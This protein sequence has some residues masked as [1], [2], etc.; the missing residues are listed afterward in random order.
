MVMLVVSGECLF[1]V[2]TDVLTTKLTMM[3]SFLAIFWISFWATNAFFRAGKEMIFSFTHSMF[4]FAI[5]T[6]V[7]LYLHLVCT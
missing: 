1:Y 6:V 3:K 7:R 2:Y 5:T 4:T